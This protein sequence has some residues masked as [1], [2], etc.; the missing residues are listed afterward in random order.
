[1]FYI[2]ASVST[3]SLVPCLF[4]VHAFG[5]FPVLLLKTSLLDAVLVPFAHNNAKDVMLYDPTVLSF[6]YL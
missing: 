1:M 5:I 3:C 6:F 2:R 4:I